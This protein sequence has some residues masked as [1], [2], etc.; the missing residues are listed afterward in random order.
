MA[1]LASIEGKPATRSGRGFGRRPPK[2]WSCD[3][4]VFTESGTDPEF[5][6]VVA[7]LA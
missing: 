1:A 3:F 4:C 2:S 7:A 5:E 6:N